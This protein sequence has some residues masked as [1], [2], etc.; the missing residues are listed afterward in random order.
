LEKSKGGQ[1]KT[2]DRL[3]NLL[4]MVPWEG[5]ENIRRP[6]INNYGKM[7][8]SGTPKT[9]GVVRAGIEQ[10]RHGGHDAQVLRPVLSGGMS[11]TK[12]VE[13]GETFSNSDI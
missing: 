6:A 13:S 5:V 10:K 11:A 9:V 4:K 2:S 8:G 12:W 3:E 7:T 1:G